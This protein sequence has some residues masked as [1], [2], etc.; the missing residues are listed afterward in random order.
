M[1]VGG[2]WTSLLYPLFPRPARRGRK[3][4]LPKGPR[5]RYTICR[6]F[7]RR[8]RHV[9]TPSLLCPVGRDHRLGLSPGPPG[10]L[11]RPGPVL[12]PLLRPHRG[13][14][15]HRP[16][17]HRPAAGA[18]PGGA[19]G[20]PATGQ[21]GGGLPSRRPGAG[22]PGIRG[23]QPEPGLPLGHRGGQGQGGGLSIPAPGPGRLPGRGLSPH[24]SGHLHQDPHR[25]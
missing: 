23:G 21:P 25:G 18:Q 5:P 6:V 9:T 19:G 7:S 15:P 17:A 16:G 13:Q 14:P 8:F 4:P 11:P 2:R 20:P 3:F 22:R 10:P 24:P 12:R 1:D